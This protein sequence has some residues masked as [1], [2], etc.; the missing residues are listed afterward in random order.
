MND[1][2]NNDTAPVV[3]PVDLV[4]LERHPGVVAQRGQLGARARTSMQPAICIDI[5]H[6]FDVDSVV[7]TECEPTDTI[8][9][10]D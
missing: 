9:L 5:V 8:A 10:E 7:K 1:A 3:R 4:D 6:R 2:V